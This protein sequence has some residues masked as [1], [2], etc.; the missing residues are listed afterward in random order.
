MRIRRNRAITMV[1]N[2]QGTKQQQRSA[3]PL[4]SL[5]RDVAAGAI[6][7]FVNQDHPSDG[8]HNQVLPHQPVSQNEQSALDND[9]HK[10]PH[11]VPL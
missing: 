10:D 7:H 9:R 3:P 11:N 5:Y 8:R 6:N 1:T 2:N 4:V